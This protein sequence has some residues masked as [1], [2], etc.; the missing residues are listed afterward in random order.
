MGGF[1]EGL[2]WPQ[3]PVSTWAR[4]RILRVSFTSPLS[5]SSADATSGWSGWRETREGAP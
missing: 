2:L 4:K 5:C 3:G 1:V